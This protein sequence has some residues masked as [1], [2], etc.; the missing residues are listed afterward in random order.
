MFVEPPGGAGEYGQDS[1]SGQKSI[2][3]HRRFHQTETPE[4]IT[5]MGRQTTLIQKMVAV[6]RPVMRRRRSSGSLGRMEI[7]SSSEVSQFIMLSARSRLAM[8]RRGSD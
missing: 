7:R 8:G 6:P 1:R 3:F 4:A 5:I 2:K